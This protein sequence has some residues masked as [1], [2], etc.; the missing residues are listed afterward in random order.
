MAAV[1]AMITF[2]AASNFLVEIP[3]NNWLTWGTFT[4]PFTFLVSELTNRFYGPRL[5]RRVV[6]FGFAAAIALSFSL[7]NRR[8][9]L[10][11]S[12]AFLVG[13]LLDI[14]VFNRLRRQT[15]WV[16][17]AGAS[18]AASF[19]DTLIFFSL[20]FAGTQVPWV[21]LGL[22]D[23]GIKVLMDLGLLLP[24]RLALWR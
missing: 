10:A 15:W 8:I 3:I 9:A 23:F 16:A 11:S 1:F 24:F 6:Y 2:T 4:Y 22:G 18:F 17:P 12:I 14:S 19:V 7:L 13:Q 20:A 21:T 5:A